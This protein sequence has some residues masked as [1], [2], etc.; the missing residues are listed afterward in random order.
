MTDLGRPLCFWCPA[1]LTSS[2]FMILATELGDETFIIAAVMSMRH[3]KFVVFLCRSLYVAS[4]SG[5]A[6]LAGTLQVHATK[7]VWVF[8]RGRFQGIF[9]VGPVFSKNSVPA[10]LT[11]NPILDTPCTAYLPIHWGGFRGQC[12]YL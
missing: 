6:R 1:G 3:P 4:L 12:S 7:F 11:K 8:L 10:F 9:R 5:V 2:F